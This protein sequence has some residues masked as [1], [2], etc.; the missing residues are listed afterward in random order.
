MPDY[1][2]G[3]AAFHRGT[4]SGSSPY[5]DTKRRIPWVKGWFDS[6]RDY[7]ESLARLDACQSIRR[8]EHADTY[9]FTQRGG[10]AA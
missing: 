4:P 3:R 10:K 5:A 7:V 8:F 1:A 9:E 6:K 2:E